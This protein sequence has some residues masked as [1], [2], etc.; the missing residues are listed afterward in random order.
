LTKKS[1]KE[2]F[3]CIGCRAKRLI[4]AREIIEEF[5]LAGYSA[6]PVRASVVFGPE[7]A[8]SACLHAIRSVGRGETSSHDIGTVIA[9]Y[10]GCNRQISKALAAVGI[11][12]E[13]EIVIITVPASDGPEAEKVLERLGMERDDS[14]M[15]IDKGKLK[16]ASLLG[17]ESPDPE[18][19][20]EAVLERVALVDLDL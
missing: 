10:L 2:S 17:I 13:K 3:S 12:G 18:T 11:D 1:E 8:A 7:H 16:N 5:A 9:M 6:Q 20:K 15:G 14:L 19:V 4:S